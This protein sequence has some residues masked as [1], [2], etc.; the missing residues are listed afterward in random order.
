MNKICS[1]FFKTSK[2][3]LSL[4][5]QKQIYTSQSKNV[6]KQFTKQSN[7]KHFSFTKS[8][9]Y[10]FIHFLLIFSKQN[11]LKYFG[12]NIISEIPIWK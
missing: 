10:K 5:V 2:N 4:S 3:A 6:L 7:L 12:N 9:R 11:K 8:L 1:N